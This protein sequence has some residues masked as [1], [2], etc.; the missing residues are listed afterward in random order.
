[1]PSI[2]KNKK[3]S[4]PKNAAE[5]IKLDAIISEEPKNEDSKKVI[6]RTPHFE[7][8]DEDMGWMD[9]GNKKHKNSYDESDDDMD[10]LNE[11]DSEEMDESD[12]IFFREK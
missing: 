10:D 9:T 7:E 8:E 4:E 12:E 6:P 5:E 1:M 11:D 2:K 3:S